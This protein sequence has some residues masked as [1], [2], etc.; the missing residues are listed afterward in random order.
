MNSATLKDLLDK[1]KRHALSPQEEAAF[2]EAVSAAGQEDVVLADIIQELQQST[3]HEGMTTGVQLQVL[4]Q[5]QARIGRKPVAR[6][7]GLRRLLPY[8]AAVLVLVAAGGYWLHMGKKKE[9]TTPVATVVL[10]GSNKAILTTSTGEQI[11]LGAGHHADIPLQGGVSVQQVGDEQLAYQ[12]T[13]VSAR[14]VTNTLATPLGGQFQ[15]VLA[16]GTK[17]WLNAG[18]TLTYPA[19]FTA[20]ERRV[21]LEG[22]AYFE[23]AAHA[24]QPFKVVVKG[25]EV[26]VL[27]THFNIMAY[28][29]EPSTSATLLEG[30]VKVI[31]DGASEIL[32][33]GTQASLLKTGHQIRVAAVDTAMAVAWKNGNLQLQDA[34]IGTIMRQVARWYNVQVQ[35]E[36]AISDRHFSLDISRDISLNDLLVVLAATGVHCRLEDKVVTVLK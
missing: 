29:D 2:M 19:A 28:E 18:S 31:H 14:L 36:Q 10:P 7:V 21:T 11:L 27:G 25:M 6:R 20:T 4:Q 34:D 17:V 22:E 35:Y 3:L 24:A 15:V 9:A 30:A 5:I 33:P 26:Q 12:E 16:D 13:P 32:K 23:V 8:A 1:Y